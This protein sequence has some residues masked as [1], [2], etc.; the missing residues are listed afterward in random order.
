MDRKNVLINLAAIANKLDKHGA[1]REANVLTGVMK[2]VSQTPWWQNEAA[3]PM[4]SPDAIR[5]EESYMPDP[6]DFADPDNDNRWMNADDGKAEARS[7]RFRDVYRAWLPYQ[8]DLS[9]LQK[10]ID[11]DA[12]NQHMQKGL[13]HLENYKN[14]PNFMGE[15]EWMKKLERESPRNTDLREILESYILDTPNSKH[16]STWFDDPDTMHNV[17][18]AAK[19]AMLS[20]T[21][22]MEAIN[23]VPAEGQHRQQYEGP[24]DLGWDGGRED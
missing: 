11:D 18:D 12:R 21:D 13:S 3:E 17:L 9:V 23:S 24:E 1:Y 16:Q 22:V 14:S 4:Y 15:E 20:G 7:D 8:S 6:E 10:K 2:R 5:A 19:N